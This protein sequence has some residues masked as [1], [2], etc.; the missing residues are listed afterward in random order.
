MAQLTKKTRRPPEFDPKEFYERRNKVLILRPGGGIGDILMHRLMFEDIKMQHPDLELHFACPPKYQDFVRGHPFV[1]KVLNSDTIDIHQY[2][3]SY[4]V[5]SAC[6]RYEQGHYPDPQMHRADIWAEQC[7]VTLTHHEGYLSASE[8]MRQ[9]GLAILDR[10]HMNQPVALLCPYSAM[11]MRNMLPQQVENLTKIM[12]E[13]GVDV[14]GCHT[15]EIGMGIPTATGLTTSQWMGLM[16]V[17]DYVVTTDT[18]HFHMAGLLKKQMLGIFAMTNGKVYGKYYPNWELVQKH[19]DNGDWDCGPCYDTS[20]CPKT[21][22]AP[23]PCMSSIT[24]DML[25]EGWGRLLVRFPPN[26]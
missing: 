6:L 17:V 13:S 18:S 9:E 16:S 25:Q 4:N 24:E 10:F 3:I 14:L 23:Y 21:G 7:G 11:S 20:R 12:R 15:D 19:R 26:K 5:G 2:L 22:S 1:D 8:D